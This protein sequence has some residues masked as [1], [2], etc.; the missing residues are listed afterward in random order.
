MRYELEVIPY[1]CGDIP[2]GVERCSFA[3]ERGTKVYVTEAEPVNPQS[4][5][6]FWKQY[7]RQAATMYRDSKEAALLPKEYAFKVQAVKSGDGGKEKRR[8]VGKLHLN[9]AQFCTDRMDAKPQEMMLQL[10][11]SGKLKVSIKATWLRDA[12]IDQ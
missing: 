6:V 3:W 10:K 4:H 11:P 2:D 5:A 12:R 7:L 1:F 8:T 9:M